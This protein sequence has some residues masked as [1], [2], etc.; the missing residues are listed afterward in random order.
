M[1]SSVVNPLLLLDS[2]MESV[3]TSTF[4]TAQ[5]ATRRHWGW[6]ASLR[7]MMR[8]TEAKLAK[9]SVGTGNNMAEVGT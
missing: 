6:G 7:A 9:M 2:A 4:Q 8:R 5:A 3:E 1:I